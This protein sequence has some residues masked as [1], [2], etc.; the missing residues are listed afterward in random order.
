MRIKY[1]VSVISVLVVLV[2][3]LFLFGNSNKYADRCGSFLA[4]KDHY[5]YFG[6]GRFYIM[7]IVSHKS[8]FDYESG[9]TGIMLDL[10]K[11]FLKGSRLYIEGYF[12]TGIAVPGNPP[13]LSYDIINQDYIT[14]NSIEEVPRYTILNIE[15]GETDLYRTLDEISEEDRLIFEKR[16][17]SWCKFW[18]TCYEKG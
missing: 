16:L 17:N 15:T 4:C 7:S 8:L 12:V 2:A 18:R 1:I 11:Y 5:T 14:Y 13:F 3:A 10:D 9:S 6:D